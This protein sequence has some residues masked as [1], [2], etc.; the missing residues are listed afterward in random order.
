[1]TDEEFLKDDATPPGSQDPKQPKT[2]GSEEGSA[3][4]AD[5]LPTRSKRRGCIGFLLGT[6][7]GILFFP[8]WL[9]PRMV[10]DRRG[11]RTSFGLWLV[12]FFIWLYIVATPFVMVASYSFGQ[13]STITSSQREH[14]NV[15]GVAY[16]DALIHCYESSMTHWMVNDRIAPTIFLDN[17]QNFQLG[18]REGV[19]Y[20][21]R[22]LRDNLSRQRSTDAID[23]DVRLAHERL[24]YDPNHWIIP[25][26]ETSIREGIRHLRKYRERLITGQAKF[27]PRADNLA[28]LLQQ[29]NSVTGGAN[30]RLTN[31]IP[32]AERKIGEETLGD[33][34][35]SGEEIVQTRVP[36]SKVDDEFYYARGVAFA[37]REVMVAINHDFRELLEQRNAQELSKSIV[38]DFLD[39][40]QIEPIYVA[41]GG[42][43]S[44][45]PNHP[46][47]LLGVLSQVREK[48]RSL[49][50][51]VAID[52]R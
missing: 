29:F 21:T 35:L 44:A 19:L 36:W 33:P 20:G 7:L 30:V 25:Q 49:H 5:P 27:Y 8:F 43:D 1:M 4:G 22:V 41:N 23:E 45:W 50:T 39:R 32:G 2:G 9:Y 52:V 31:C 11:G 37:Y 48:S 18:V 16:V 51:M 34:T 26:S 12:L 28:E 47:K 15:D 46:A 38:V 24:S 40:V 14:A 17:P 10:R 42:L 3:L 13:P 6:L